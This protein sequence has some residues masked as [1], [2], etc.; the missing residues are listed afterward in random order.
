[1]ARINYELPEDL[2]RRAKAAAALEGSSLKDF[3]ISALAAA[4]ERAE[5]AKR[6]PRDR[7]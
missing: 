1:V 6:K 7:C 4:V 3:V 2:H 5:K